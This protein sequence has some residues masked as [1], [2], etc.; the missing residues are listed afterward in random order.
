MVSRGLYDYMAYG[1][2]LLT[3][4]ELNWNRLGVLCDLIQRV[5]FSVPQCPHGEWANVQD[6]CNDEAIVNGCSGIWRTLNT[7]PF[8]CSVF[9]QCC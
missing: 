7:C 1:L 8:H 6:C 5:L 3:D 4:T 2:H 9:E